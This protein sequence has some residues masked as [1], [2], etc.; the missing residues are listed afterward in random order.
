MM[1]RSMCLRP[2]SLASRGFRGASLLSR[3]ALACA[4]VPCSAAIVPAQDLRLH[5]DNATVLVEPY[6]PDIVRVSLSLNRA[7]ALAAPVPR[8][9]LPTIA[10]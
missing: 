8:P 3:L 1:F 9:G 4:V 6:A 10:P 5:R 2:I 7:D